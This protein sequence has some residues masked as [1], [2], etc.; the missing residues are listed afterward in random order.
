[1]TRSRRPASASEAGLRGG[2]N[3]SVN[4]TNVGYDIVHTFLRQALV[5]EVPRHVAGPNLLPGKTH[6]PPITPG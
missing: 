4:P 5:E 6:A 1:M 3:L 2:L